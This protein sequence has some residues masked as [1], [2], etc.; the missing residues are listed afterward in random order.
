MYQSQWFLFGYSLALSEGSKCPFI[1][2][3]G[4]VL[5]YGLDEPSDIGEDGGGRVVPEVLFCIYHSMVAGITPALVVGAI[6]ERGRFL[7]TVSKRIAD[8]DWWR[9]GE[10]IIR[11]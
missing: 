4:R 7:P 10:V 5:L 11:V 3:F 8:T 9:L 6:A 1:G 2:G